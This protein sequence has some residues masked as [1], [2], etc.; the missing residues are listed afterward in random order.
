MSRRAPLSLLALVAAL[1]LTACDRRHAPAPAPEPAAAPRGDEHNAV[2]GLLSNGQTVE[3]LT[4][5][6]CHDV[7]RP[8]RAK[9]RFSHP[10][11]TGYGLH[12]NTCHGPEDHGTKPAG[13]ARHTWSVSKACGQC[14]NGQRAPS[15]CTTCHLNPADYKPDSHRDATWAKQHGK[16]DR[17]SCGN[18]HKPAFCADC[19]QTEMPHPAGWQGRHGSEA[20]HQPQL[21]GRCHSE[22]TCTSCHG[23][24]MPH[25]ASWKRTHGQANRNLCAKCHQSQTCDSCHGLTMPH[26]SGWLKQHSA[27]AKSNPALCGKCHSQQT[28]RACHGT[29]I[30]HP[31]GW[32]TGH[33]SEASFA[34]GNKCAKCHQAS[35]CSKCH[36][37]KK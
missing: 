14:H 24:T 12:C 34:P 9:V 32:V 16:G 13:A 7:N 33:G 36:V 27:S 23:V 26:P 3:G 35:F 25:P 2:A 18:C 31:A 28:C 29:T 5:F 1:A 10:Q 19:H 8:R 11:H 15:A 17:G 21:C 4:C 37:A 30:P 22:N 20:R 6:K